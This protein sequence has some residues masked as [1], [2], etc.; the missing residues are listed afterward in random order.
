M[1]SIEALSTIRFWYLFFADDEAAK[2]WAEHAMSGDFYTSCQNYFIDFVLVGEKCN[3]MIT[4]AYD[5]C[6]ECGE[7]R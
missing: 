7:I 4:P 1:S 3:T 6:S 2:A 5:E